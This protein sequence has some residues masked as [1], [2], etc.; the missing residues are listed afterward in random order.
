[1]SSLEPLARP[2]WLS[3]AA[4]PWTTAA[5]RTPVGRIAVTDAGTGPTL[6]LV[7]TGMW[8][9]VWRDLLRELTPNFRCVTLDAPGNGRSDPPGPDGPRLAGSTAAVETVV[10]ALD[11]RDITLVAHDL[12]GVAGLAAAA[13]APER[14]A[15][16]AAVN[17]FGW[18]PSGAAFRG[19]LGF[20]GSA[21][22]RESDALTGW[23]PAATS[24]R[25]GA[26]RSW[27]RADRA[28]FR[29]G[30]DRG[31]R[32]AIHRYLGDAR[33]A[34]PLYD[35]IGAALSGPLRDRPLL[36]VFGQHND[37]LQFQPKWKALFPAARQEVVAGGNHFPMCDAPAE[38]A[39]W[40]RAWHA[41]HV[42]AD[43]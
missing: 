3:E 13:R 43:Q 11:L 12:G 29:A 16:I 32:R 31:G 14:Y 9:F 26:G 30:I 39:G 22:V 17:T 19:M 27:S 24:G 34:D 37:P 18:R 35:E 6:L 41:T 42:R 23:L 8:S 5:V 1:M 21:P 7:H 33:H 20:I 40:I 2:A 28:T 4:W 25:F 38:V 36:T 15:A 10:E